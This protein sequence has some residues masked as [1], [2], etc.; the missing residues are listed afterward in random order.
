MEQYLL[1]STVISVNKIN[2]QSNS[3][4][5]NFEFVIIIERS[6]AR[7]N[8]C[9]LFLCEIFVNLFHLKNGW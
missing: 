1:K 7:A 6:C 9:N 4:I 2:E 3:L 8:V 5:F